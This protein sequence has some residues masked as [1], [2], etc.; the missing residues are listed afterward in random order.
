[1]V[2]RGNRPISAYSQVVCRAAF[3]TENGA[4]VGD[5]FMSL[6]HT[7]EL[8][9]A[10]SFDYLT[11]LQR[12][13]DELAANPAAWMPWDY[14]ETMARPDNGRP[15]DRRSPQIAGASHRIAPK[16]SKNSPRYARAPERHV[17]RRRSLRAALTCC[18]IVT[19]RKSS[20]RED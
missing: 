4:H 6:I 12:H 5:I 11:E 14:R 13:S 8:G 3:K 18:G 1:M 2:P 15:C 20:V 10:D 9:G 17:F 19:M 16:I 7:C